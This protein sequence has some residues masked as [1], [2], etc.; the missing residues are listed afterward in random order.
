MLSVCTVN[1]SILNFFEESL[2]S[3]P[4]F[5]FQSRTERTK[6]GESRRMHNDYYTE[7]SREAP[8]NRLSTCFCLLRTTIAQQYTSTKVQ[9]EICVN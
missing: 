6:V 2:K 3:I 5:K 4:N 7:V 9:E 1:G 8:L